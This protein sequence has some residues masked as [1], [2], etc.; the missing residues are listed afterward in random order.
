MAV[1]DDRRETEMRVLF[2]LDKD[3]SEGRSGT[4]ARLLIDGVELAFELKSSTEDSV[5]TVRDFGLDHVLKWENKHWLFGFYDKA[6]TTLEYCLYASP[7]QMQPWISRMKDYISPDIELASLL[8][9]HLTLADLSKICEAKENYSLED[10]K[11]IQR[12]QYSI[13]E[14]MALMD[15]KPGYSPERM[16]SIVKE[17]VRYLILRGST[18][19]NPHIP[20]SY[21]KGWP[22]ITD[23]HANILRQRVRESLG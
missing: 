13:K 18:L 6:G 17:R 19:N 11:R 20:G 14:Y 7:Q 10:A 9:E 21:F 12:K 2:E 22:K 16:L 1:Q 4:D 5:T 3:H 15:L 8:S 23:D